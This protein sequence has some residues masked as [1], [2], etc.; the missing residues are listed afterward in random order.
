M[1]SEENALTTGGAVP[2][3]VE[4]SYVVSLRDLD[5]K[6]VKDFIFLHGET[7]TSSIDFVSHNNQPLAHCWFDLFGSLLQI[8][9]LDG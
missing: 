5:M 8:K 7:T 9:C 4:S 1:V 6:H 2:A 3:R